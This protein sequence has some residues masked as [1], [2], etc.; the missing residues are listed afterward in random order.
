MIWM[1]LSCSSCLAWV[2]VVGFNSRVEDNS[3]KNFTQKSAER[4]P[5]F[6][7]FI[8]KKLQTLGRI[9]GVWSLDHAG[10]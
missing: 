4:C 3:A 10:C 5:F 6:R 9:V 2:A 7:P 8:V 1:F